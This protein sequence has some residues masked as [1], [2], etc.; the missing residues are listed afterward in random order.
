MNNFGK[1]TISGFLFVMILTA[2][3]FIH[4][5]CFFTL[6]FIINIIGI[7]EFSHMANII[8][9]KINRPLCIICGSALFTAGFLDNYLNYREGYLYF[10]ITTFILGICE[11]YRKRTHAFQNL[12]FSIY[13]LFYLTLPFTLLIYFPYICTDHWQ[14]AIIFFP[15][16]LVWFNDT[17]AYLFGSK[18]GKHKLF[19]RISPKKSWEGAIGGGVMTIIAGLMIAPYID[20][21]SI[22]DTTI[23]SLIVVVFGSFGDLIESMFK[24]CIEIKD[25]GH[26][27]PGHGGVLDRLDSLLFA[28]PV[29]F[30]YLALTFNL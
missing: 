20:G 5:L 18:F 30:V 1:R 27:L 19:P 4:P 11:L 25:S 26:I 10:F 22:V 12:A 21:L 17:F 16:M 15:F 8:H 29:I 9:I 28:L 23:I 24:R 2:C 3:I 14:P 6:F 13:V 7:L